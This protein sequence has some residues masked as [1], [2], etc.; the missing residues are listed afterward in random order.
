MSRE[1]KSLATEPSQHN[2]ETSRR[3]S[4]DG[5]IAVRRPVPQ[6]TSLSF[7][8][9][10]RRETEKGG[11]ALSGGM[12]GEDG[13]GSTTV[14]G[15][16]SVN[17]AVTVAGGNSPVAPIWWNLYPSKYAQP[18]DASITQPFILNLRVGKL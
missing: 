5:A 1:S 14:H 16:S 18:G 2:R 10:L 13:A 4:R 7:E 15:A 12:D 9:A 3:V 11:A 8:A 6:V 17:E